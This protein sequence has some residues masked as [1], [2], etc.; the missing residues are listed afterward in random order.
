MNDSLIH[1]RR[2]LPANTGDDAI[3]GF[4]SSDVVSLDELLAI[5]RQAYK[6]LISTLDR[7]IA[8]NGS[9]RVTAYLQEMVNRAQLRLHLLTSK[10]QHH[11]SKGAQ[12]IVPPS[13]VKHSLRV[14]TRR[15]SAKQFRFWESAQQADLFKPFEPEEQVRTH[16]PLLYFGSELQRLGGRAGAAQRRSTAAQPLPPRY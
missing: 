15:V 9:D 13:S 5:S 12:T 11:I 3:K 14:S 16:I 2:F 10:P 6:R 8:E 1:G 7:E 4:D